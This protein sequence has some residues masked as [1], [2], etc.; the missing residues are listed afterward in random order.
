M[1]VRPLV[2]PTA[3]QRN[4]LTS[5]LTHA[6][7]QTPL[8]STFLFPGR[9]KLARLFLRTM[10]DYALKAGRV[11]VATQADGGIA[12]CAL[13]STPES[14]E[15]TLGAM[16]RLGL[17]PRMAW[18]ALRSPAAAH[19]VN[20][21]FTMLNRYGPDFPCATLEFLASSQKGAGAAVLTQSMTAFDGLPLYV[22]SI[23][24][25]NDHAFYRR[26]GFTPFAYTDFHG[27]NYAFLLLNAPE[28]APQK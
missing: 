1:D 24:S 23:V 11:F 9:P 7:W 16:L 4:N 17:L 20:E 13:W 26:F 2:S 25:K 5:L 10:L 8:F 15:L 14:P 27:T 21:L 22:E 19:R 12:A 18:L 28:D 3:S 6:F